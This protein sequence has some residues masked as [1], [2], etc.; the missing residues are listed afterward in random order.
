MARKRRNY[1]NKKTLTAAEVDILSEY[2]KGNRTHTVARK[3]PAEKLE[4]RG[5]GVI[6]FGYSERATLE[7]SRLMVSPTLG[8][9]DLLNLLSAI[10]YA[11]LGLETVLANVSGTLEAGYAFAPAIFIPTFMP[12]GATATN[13]T[14]AFTGRGTKRFPTRSGSL[15]FGRTTSAGTRDATTGVAETTIDAVDEEDVKASLRDKMAASADGT[16]GL[17]N[18]R[19]LM[20]HTFLPEEFYPVGTQVTK[21]IGTYLPQAPTF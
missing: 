3:L 17:F 8:A 5:G 1:L 14:S 20:T 18:T 13:G 11:D 7:A 6:P 2:L 10:N 21:E 9:L 12:N 15:P 16:T 19:K 4:R